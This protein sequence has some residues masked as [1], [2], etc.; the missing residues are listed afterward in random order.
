VSVRP[1][2]RQKLAID[3]RVRR[4]RPHGAMPSGPLLGVSERVTEGPIEP[5]DA[6]WIAPPALD[7][8]ASPWPLVELLPEPEA[9]RGALVVV[10]PVAATPGFFSR[11]LGGGDRALAR[12]VRGAALLLKGYRSIGGGVDPSTGLDLT[13]G[14]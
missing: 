6:L 5:G 1:G 10:A 12:S 7:D 3:G 8:R 4:W 13:W 2:E 11:L 9:V 14:E